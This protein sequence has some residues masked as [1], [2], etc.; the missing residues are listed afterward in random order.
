MTFLRIVIPLC[1]SRIFSGNRHPL[2]V[3][4][5][6]V[7]SKLSTRRASRRRGTQ[8]TPTVAVLFCEGGEAPREIEEAA[9]VDGCTIM[10]TFVKTVLPLSVPG[11]LTVVIFAFRLTMPELV[12]PRPSS[13]RRTKGR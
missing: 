12:Y 4:F 13:P 1:W 5:D 6:S 2:F 10:G 9:I 3:A 7:C 8:E 11:I